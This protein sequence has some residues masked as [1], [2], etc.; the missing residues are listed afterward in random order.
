[1][2]ILRL[3]LAICVI[4]THSEKILPWGSH[5]GREAVQIFFII[6]GFYMQL[7]LSGGGKYG[8]VTEFYRSRSLRIYFPYFISLAVVVLIS[9]LTGLLSGDWLTLSAFH[10]QLTGPEKAGAGTVFAT[11]SNGTL[12]FQDWVMFLDQ[13]PAGKLTFTSNFLNS[14]HPL[15]HFLWIP[16]A[17]SVG[18]ELTFYLIA[19]FLVR[20][21]SNSALL[22]VAALSFLARFLAYWKLGWYTDPWSYRFFPFELLNFCYGILGCRLMQQ[23]PAIFD[24]I[25]GTALRIEKKLGRW[26]YPLLVFSGLAGLCAHRLLF[27]TVGGFADKLIPR[28]QELVYFGSIALWGLIVP[29]LFSFTRNNRTDRAVGELSYPVY[30]LH[31]TVCV[32]LLHW[33]S[34]QGFPK[35]LVGE[36]ATVFTI[37]IAILLQTHV[38]EPFEKWR[39]ASVRKNA[40]TAPGLTT[41]TSAV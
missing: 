30:L 6:S 22:M 28:G 36:T 20:K 5:G 8:S 9:S 15:W 32:L 34:T 18:V 12:F 23:R 11:L 7:I 4:A 17:W 13:T 33:V 40:K 27:S 16:Q 26:H 37:V 19:P 21:L 3:Y 38:L 24:R 1:M 29:I 41:P 14:A 2:G 31:Y 35:Y 25:T 10:D 39:Q